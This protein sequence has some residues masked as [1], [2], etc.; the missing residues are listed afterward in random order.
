MN[1]EIFARKSSTFAYSAALISSRLSVLKKLSQLAL[2]PG[3]AGRLTLA[4]M[5]YLLSVSAPR[6]HERHKLKR[7]C[8]NQKSFAHRVKNTVTNIRSSRILAFQLA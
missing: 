6:A 8:F 1:R 5:L 4:R 3:L 2:S 7:N